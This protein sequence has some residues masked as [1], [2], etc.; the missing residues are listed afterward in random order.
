MRRELMIYDE[1]I[2]CLQA[3]HTNARMGC[4]IVGV[5]RP[6]AT[7]HGVAGLSLTVAPALLAGQSD[8]NRLVVGRR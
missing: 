7:W 3:S 1:V 6:G 5:C 8:Y 4:E 2:I